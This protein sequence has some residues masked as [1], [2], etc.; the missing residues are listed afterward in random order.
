MLGWA[1]GSGDRVVV[2]AS[3]PKFRTDRA[4]PVVS[5]IKMFGSRA[6]KLHDR[7]RYLGGRLMQRGFA[8]MHGH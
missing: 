8:L 4:V 1:T 5:L 6:E 2:A 7:P 3:A